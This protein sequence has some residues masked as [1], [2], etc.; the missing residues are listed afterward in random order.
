MTLRSILIPWIL[1]LAASCA[2]QAPAKQTPEPNGI[3]TGHVF[4]ADIGLPA[5]FAYVFL[6]PII[7]PRAKPEKASPSS[8]KPSYKLVRNSVETALDGTF[9]LTHVAPGVY[10][11]SVE[12]DGYINPVMMVGRPHAP[13]NLTL[14]PITSSRIQLHTSMYNSSA[15]PR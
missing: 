12:K 1:F 5:R 15:A 11:L 13:E 2:A 10:N 7:D 4:C 9:T 3:V 6:S 8:A 14:Q